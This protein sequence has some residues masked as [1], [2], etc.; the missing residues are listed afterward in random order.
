MQVAS[1][2]GRVAFAGRILGVLRGMLA[3]G[4]LPPWELVTAAVQ[5]LATRLLGTLD[6]MPMDDQRVGTEC[7]CA[8]TCNVLHAG[9]QSA[10]SSSC[11][12]V[13]PGPG[14]VQNNRRACKT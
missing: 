3:L 7:A 2:I 6:C 14:T 5:H 11:E 8:H 4:M 1:G 9:L 12:P 13:P 10:A